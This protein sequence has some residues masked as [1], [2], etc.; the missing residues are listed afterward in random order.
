MG[1]K[2]STHEDFTLTLT[3]RIIIIKAQ[4][5]E[6]HN[7]QHQPLDLIFGFI[8]QI[9]FRFWD[10]KIS[11]YAT[12]LYLFLPA[13]WRWG[14]VSRWRNG[15]RSQA[16]IVVIKRVCYAIHYSH[17]SAKGCSTCRFFI[18]QRKADKKPLTE[19]ESDGALN[20]YHFWNKL[21]NAV[22]TLPSLSW[23]F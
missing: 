4:A 1:L 17:G 12:F 15:Q 20:R 18:T 7:D 16:Q 6:W 9:N 5:M 14:S 11:I 3:R 13:F 10:V 19:R 21:P 2:R 23:P 8:F 22:C